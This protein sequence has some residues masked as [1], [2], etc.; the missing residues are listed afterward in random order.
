MT[1]EEIQE[2]ITNILRIKSEKSKSNWYELYFNL[3]ISR[4]VKKR[5]LPE[6][7]PK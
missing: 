5:Y 6:G 1:P 4:S 2:T 7:N 3:L